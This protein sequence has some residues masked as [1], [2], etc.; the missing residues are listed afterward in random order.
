MS[1]I[2]DN[3]LKKVRRFNS[4]QKR[5]QSNIR[6]EIPQHI[7]IE[8]TKALKVLGKA[9]VKAQKWQMK[10]GID[11]YDD[12]YPQRT[13]EYLDYLSR[14]GRSRTTYM[15]KSGKLLRSLRHYKPRINKRNID[16]SYVTVGTPRSQRDKGRGLIGNGY[17][18]HQIS[19]HSKRVVLFK[20]GRY[21]L[22]TTKNNRFRR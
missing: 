9:A 18:W 17:F 8:V 21:N 15:Q 12:R 3:Y 1:R 16:R 11:R 19:D 20:L 10:E 14:N 2:T 4:K 7:Q 6:I 5:K 13:P 22:M